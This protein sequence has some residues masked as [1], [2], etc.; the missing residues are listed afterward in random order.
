MVP[1]LGDQDPADLA[2]G[3]ARPKPRGESITTWPVIRDIAAAGRYLWVLA[4]DG[5]APGGERLDVVLPGEQLERFSLPLPASMEHERF[6]GVTRRFVVLCPA[7][8]GRPVTLDRD[9]IERLAEDHFAHAAKDEKPAPTAS[10]TPAAPAATP[11][12]GGN[13]ADPAGVQAP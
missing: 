5:K 4:R 9:E 7:D 2:G 8:N 12:P 10:A 13:E 6:L 3:D 1:R 11:P